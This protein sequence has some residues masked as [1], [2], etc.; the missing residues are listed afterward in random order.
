MQPPRLKDLTLLRKNWTRLVYQLSLILLFTLILIELATRLFWW[1]QPVVTMFDRELFL[2][3]LPLISQ[4]HKNILLSWQNTPDRYLKFDPML[5]LYF[6]VL[7]VLTCAARMTVDW[8]MTREH[9]RAND[10]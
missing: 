4:K 6:V 9:Q 5:T 10:R 2:V 7:S 3:P 8:G 1:G